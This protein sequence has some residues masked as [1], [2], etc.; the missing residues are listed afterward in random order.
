[1][2][3]VFLDRDGTLNRYKGYITQAQEIELTDGA[4]KAVKMINDAGYLAVV[5][6][7]QPQV[8]RGLCGI[9]DVEYING[10]T[11]ALLAEEGAYL[12]SILFCPHHPDSG[13]EG[14]RKEYKINCS[15]RKPKPGLIFEAAEKYNIDLSESYVVGDS[16]RDIE[17]GKSAGCMTAFI[18]RESGERS[19]DGCEKFGSLYDFA[20]KYFK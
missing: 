4:A 2:K 15:C 5:V 7:N 14:E 8:A 11:E 16:V 1:M 20:L 18:E 9:E 17:A 12:D 6:S 19:P 13:F 10:R 3:A